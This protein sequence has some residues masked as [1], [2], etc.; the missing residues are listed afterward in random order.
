MFYLIIQQYM[1]DTLRKNLLYYKKYF[2]KY[3]REDV[4]HS[5]KAGETNNSIYKI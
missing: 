4:V 1:A 2:N 3:S 5:T